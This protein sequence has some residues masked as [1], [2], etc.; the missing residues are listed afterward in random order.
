MHWVSGK[1]SSLSPVAEDTLAMFVSSLQVPQLQAVWAVL[2]FCHWEKSRLG[3]RSY[4]RDT[5]ADWAPPAVISSQ[6]YSE[7]KGR[8]STGC[9]KLTFGHSG[10]MGGR[11]RGQLQ[12]TL[13]QSFLLGS[14]PKVEFGS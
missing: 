9:L 3:E 8:D 6:G 1:P 10:G 2:L 5:L 12:P 14:A 13:E 4:M 7:S 11:V